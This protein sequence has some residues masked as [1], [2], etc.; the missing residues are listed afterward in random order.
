MPKGKARL[1]KVRLHAF[2]D[3]DRPATI[4]PDPELKGHLKA[5]VGAITFGEVKHQLAKRTALQVFSDYEDPAKLQGNLE[6]TK[7]TDRSF[8]IWTHLE[9][10]SIKKALDDLFEMDTVSSIRIT[11]M[12]QYSGEEINLF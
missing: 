6:I 7:D 5:I 10:E 11:G 2:D 1:W 3:K 12:L 8:Y 4:I 9:Y